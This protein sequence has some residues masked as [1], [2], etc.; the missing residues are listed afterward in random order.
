MSEVDLLERARA[1][2]A[3]GILTRSAT[4]DLNNQMAAI[5]SFA[6]LVLEAL[7]FEHPVRD[8]IEEIRLAGTRAIAKTR[9]LDKWARTLAPIGTHS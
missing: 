6:D 3:I 2:E 9:E 5:M 1:L 8:A 7:P 4:H